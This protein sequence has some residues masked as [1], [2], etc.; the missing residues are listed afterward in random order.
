MTR[1]IEHLQQIV[2]EAEKNLATDDP[3]V[4]KDELRETIEITTRELG[5]RAVVEGFA[6]AAPYELQRHI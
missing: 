5:G 3:N 4:I 1:K 6:L 2:A